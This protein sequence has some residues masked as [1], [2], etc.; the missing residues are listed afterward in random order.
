MDFSL[1]SVRYRVQPAQQI[2]KPLL[3]AARNAPN[4]YANNYLAPQTITALLVDV[5]GVS[6]IIWELGM[7]RTKFANE[8]RPNWSADN[9]FQVI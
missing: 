4:V 3:R 8:Y 7:T 1:F 6:G 9:E 5:L 2:S